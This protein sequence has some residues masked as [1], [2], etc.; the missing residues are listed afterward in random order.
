MITNV[1][2][3]EMDTRSIAETVE[4][5]GLVIEVVVIH[6]AN[7]RV[8]GVVGVDDGLDWVDGVTEVDDKLNWVDR[9]AGVAD[10]VD[11]HRVIGFL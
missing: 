10:K 7:S 4:I 11:I 6:E 9:V 5:K 2:A 3:E 8:A 1:A